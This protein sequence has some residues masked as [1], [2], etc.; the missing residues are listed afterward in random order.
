MMTGWIWAVLSAGLVASGCDAAPPKPPKVGEKAADFELS[1]IDGDTVQLSKLTKTAPVVVVVMRG[2]PGYQ[3]PICSQQFGQFVNKAEEFGK[4]GVQVV[5]VYPGPSA[6]LME[7]A[8]AFVK[9]Q[10]Y[11]DHFNLVIDP[12][13]AFTQSYGLRWNARNE[14]AYPST[15]VVDRSG[16][17]VYAKVSTTHG[18]RAGVQEVLK[19]LPKE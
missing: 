3:C 16:K 13:Y 15:F 4:A 11:P 7:R 9:G 12:D 19:A 2:F 5:F 1:A 10:D 6:E 14:T 8:K 17:V 18:G